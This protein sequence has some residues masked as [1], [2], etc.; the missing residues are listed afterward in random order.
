M[1]LQQD[2]R[3]YYENRQ[4]PEVNRVRCTASPENALVN[5]AQDVVQ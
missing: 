3:G 5:S 1:R 2:K 4:L